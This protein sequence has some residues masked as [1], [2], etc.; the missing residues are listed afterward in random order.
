M[1]LYLSVLSHFFLNQCSVSELFAIKF[2]DKWQKLYLY[3]STNFSLFKLFIITCKLQKNLSQRMKG[4][5]FYYFFYFYVAGPSPCQ[6][7]SLDLKVSC[8]CRWLRCGPNSSD[9]FSNMNFTSLRISAWMAYCRIKAPK[10]LYSPWRPS[11]F[12]MDLKQSRNPS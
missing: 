10:P 8:D 3:R 2:L 11:S 4:S 7:W 12:T 6:S 9:N 1:R 5:V